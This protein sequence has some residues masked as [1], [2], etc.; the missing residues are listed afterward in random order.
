VRENAQEDWGIKLC[1]RLHALPSIFPF[2]VMLAHAYP[3]FT[4]WTICTL[5]RAHACLMSSLLDDQ[6]EDLLINLNLRASLT[7][8]LEKWRYS[9]E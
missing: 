1:L 5:M 4:H 9:Y 6:P 3:T 2:R 7:A 8:G